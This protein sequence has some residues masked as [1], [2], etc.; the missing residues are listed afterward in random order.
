[1]H[2][3]MYPNLCFDPRQQI[4]HATAVILLLSFYTRVS[5]RC[6][7]TGVRLLRSSRHT[8]V[9]Y[10]IYVLLSKPKAGTKKKKK[11]R[12][13]II[14]LGSTKIGGLTAEPR[15]PAERCFKADCMHCCVSSPIQM[16]VRVFKWR[17]SFAYAHIPAPIETPPP[18]VCTVLYGGQL[19]APRADI[20]SSAVSPC[21][22]VLQQYAPPP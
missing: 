16:C 5:A 8:T 9:V 20:E 17:R 21:S 19:G 12:Y 6:F 14:Y 11:R 18:G 15:L 13:G 7:A 2:V 4:S 22:W 1:M 10:R 3:C